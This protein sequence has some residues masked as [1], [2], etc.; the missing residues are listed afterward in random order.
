MGE[1]QALGSPETLAAPTQ[2]TGIQTMSGSLDF[3]S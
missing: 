3:Y 1:L 2:R